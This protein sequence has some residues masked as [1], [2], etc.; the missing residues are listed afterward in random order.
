RVLTLPEFP[1]SQVTFSTRVTCDSETEW[2]TVIEIGG[3]Y[4]G[5]VDF[6]ASRGY[7]L[8]WTIDEDHLLERGMAMLERSS[9]E[10]VASEW[11]ST[12][13]IN[14]DVAKRFSRLGEVARIT[15]SPFKV[16][17]SK[18]SYEWNG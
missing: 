4:D 11:T 2:S 12:I 9:G 16:D 13:S 14:S 1:D 5:P 3:V 6:V 15:I 8:W 10:F 17:G 18:M 7:R